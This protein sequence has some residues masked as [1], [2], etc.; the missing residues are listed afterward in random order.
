MG[1]SRVSKA[2][3]PPTLREVSVMFHGPTSSFGWCCWGRK[4]R[5]SL[6]RRGR[7]K[8]W[9]REK[10]RD[11]HSFRWLSLRIYNAGAA[12]QV[13]ILPA[14]RQR[15]PS[16]PPPP[17]TPT[18]ITTMLLKGQQSQ[19]GSPSSGTFSDQWVCLVKGRR[20]KGELPPLTLWD[21][22]RIEKKEGLKVERKVGGFRIFELH[23]FLKLESHIY[24]RLSSHI[25]SYLCA[26][27]LWS[28]H[29]L[30]NT[31]YTPLY[32]RLSSSLSV[33][34]NE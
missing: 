19:R 17:P 2:I 22:I 25:T 13:N 5:T 28:S 10:G 8:W 32:H 6:G 4:R 3:H 16:L 9:C 1:G 26:P 12:G 15:P 24:G 18:P 7:L 14:K 20:V 30:T 29:N 23:I 33:C 31:H 11:S 34:G 21:L 27:Y